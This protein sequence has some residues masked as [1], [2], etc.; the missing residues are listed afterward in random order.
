MP[1]LQI[2]LKEP[3]H[4]IRFASKWYQRMRFTEDTGAGFKKIP[5]VGLQQWP[6]YLLM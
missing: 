6:V 5:L 3:S 2:I 1:H 4:Q